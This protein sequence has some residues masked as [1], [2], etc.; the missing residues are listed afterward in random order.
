MIFAAERQRRSTSVQRSRCSIVDPGAQ[1]GRPDARSAWTRSCAEPPAVPF[2]MIVVDD[3][4]TDATAEL[5]A[6][7]GDAGACRRRER[8]RRLRDRL[9]RRRGRG[10]AASTL[11]FLNND[12]IPQAGWLDALVAYADAHPA[13]R[14]WWAA[15]CCSRT[16]PSST[17]AS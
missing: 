4:S 7:Y 17:P 2:E 3:A 1:P 15:S 16:T 12:T 13:A 10:A 6:G 5:L 8:E 14:P 9:Q 11:V